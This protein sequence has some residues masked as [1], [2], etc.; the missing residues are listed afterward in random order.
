MLPFVPRQTETGRMSIL[1]SVLANLTTRIPGAA[2]AVTGAGGSTALPTDI[3][4]IHALRHSG[5]GL[6]AVLDRLEDKLQHSRVDFVLVDDFNVRA[7]MSGIMARLVPHGYRFFAC[8]KDGIVAELGSWLD[9]TPYQHFLA[10]HQRLADSFIF[11]TP[12]RLD[13]C[14][15]F[16]RH[17]ITVAGLIHLGAHEGEELAD[18]AR[19]GRFPVTLIEAH[20]DTYRRLEATVAAMPDVFPVHAA[21]TDRDG[22]VT[23]HISGYDE[24]NS[25][26]P[27]ATLGAIMP[28]AAEQG[29]IEVAGRSL[30]SLATEWRAQGHKAASANVVVCDIQGAELLALQGASSFLPQLEAVVLEVSFDELYEGCGQVEEIDQIMDDAGFTRVATASVQHWSWGDALYVRRR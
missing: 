27:V 17:G 28:G 1:E 30:D 3:R 13:L 24:C 20:P 18:Y 8:N 11:G 21:V 12:K 9:A 15:L 5:S 16:A 4:H 6:V 22:P 26:L 7:E 10:V 25:V 2:I 14:A 29:T 23:F 19:L